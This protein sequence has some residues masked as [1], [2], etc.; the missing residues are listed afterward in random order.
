MNRGGKTYECKGKKRNNPSCI[1]SNNH[2]A[3]CFLRQEPS[4]K[5]EL[6][7]RLYQAV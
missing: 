6:V 4:Y 1:N 7:I 3:F 5:L 2:R